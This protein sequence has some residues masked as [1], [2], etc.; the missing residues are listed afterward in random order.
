[1]KLTND[2]LVFLRFYWR[3]LID[4]KTEQECVFQA[5]ESLQEVKN[6]HIPVCLDLAVELCA[7]FA[8]MHFG[9]CK[10]RE[11]TRIEDVIRKCLPE[12]LLNTACKN[13]LK[14]IQYISNISNDLDSVF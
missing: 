9:S 4:D 14:Y 5:Y 12:K 1:M 10:H 8:Q 7:L 2:F 3:H 13:T 6:G 11:D